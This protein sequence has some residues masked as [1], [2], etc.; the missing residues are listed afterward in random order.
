MSAKA[1]FW[2]WE[3]EL[4]STQKLTLLCL[5]NCHNDSNNKCYP[6]IAYIVTSTGLNKK[7]VMQ[8]LATLEINGVIQTVKSHGKSSY[9]SFN[10]DGVTGTEINTSTKNG[11]GTKNGLGS[12][13]KNGTGV[14]PKT[15]PESKS[16]LKEN[17]KE[18]YIREIVNLELPDWLKKET[19]ISFVEYRESCKKKLTKTSASLSIAKLT[20]LKEGGNDPVEVINQTIERAYTGLFP[21]NGGNES[22]KHKAGRANQR[23]FAEPSKSFA[24]KIPD[25]APEFLRDQE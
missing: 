19:W 15:V 13:T 22:A 8:S 20:K 1:T 10:F 7:T 14:V 24:T 23:G 6:S 17:L 11:T 21:V 25:N 2:A 16:N 3:Q 5:A 9:Y 18:I 4:T 12:G